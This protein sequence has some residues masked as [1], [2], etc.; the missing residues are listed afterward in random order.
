MSNYLDNNLP[1]VI[2]VDMYTLKINGARER[3][4]QF[5]AELTAALEEEKRREEDSEEEDEADVDVGT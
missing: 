5:A 4:K 3:M 2:L 1:K